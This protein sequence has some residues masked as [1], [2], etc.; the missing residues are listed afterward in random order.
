MKSKKNFKGAIGAWLTSELHPTGAT[1]D[2]PNSNFSSLKLNGVYGELDYISIGWFGIDMSNPQSPT[3][4]TS[5]PY[6]AQQVADARAQNA[7]ITVFALLAYTNEIYADLVKIISDQN[8]LTTFA[9]NIASFLGDHN[10]NGFDID[11]EQPTSSLTQQQSGAWFDALGTAF[12]DTYYLAVSAS[13][14]Q[15]GNVQNLN[16]NAVNANVDV[17]NLQSY[18]VSD[19]SVFIAHGIDANLLGFGAYL[20]SNVTALQASQQFAQGIEYQGQKYPYQTMMSWRL[21]S[22]N[23]AFEQSQ[24]LLMRPY[25]TR[26][27]YQ[28]PFN[29]GDIL[30]VQ[31]EPTK[32]KSIVIRSGEVVDAIQSTNANSDG[33][34]VVNLLQHGGDGGTANPAIQL[35][36]GLTAFSYVTGNWYGQNVVVQITIDGKSYPSTINSSVVGTQNHQV[37]APAGQ[38]VT[39]FSGETQFVN[40]AGGG[41]TWVLS[42]IN[43]VFG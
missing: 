21:D 10:L 41:F 17:F 2:S 18:W 8:L 6:L 39:A 34:Y 35:A 38:T 23:W 26:Q 32:I 36:N 40:L 27:P 20:E 15:G 9:N 11:W 30:K 7:E 29:D 31:T 5:N 22:S 1:F 28:I 13:S 12:G 25:L 16:A 42:K 4:Q 37:T 14:N 3:L 43:A 24:Q 19:P 33:S